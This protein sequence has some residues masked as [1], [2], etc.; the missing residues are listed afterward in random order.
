MRFL[1]TKDSLERI[2]MQLVAHEAL[3]LQREM[4][5]HRAQVQANEIAK[6]F[7]S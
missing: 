2:L 5:L 6:L 3:G 1:R 4:D 7:K